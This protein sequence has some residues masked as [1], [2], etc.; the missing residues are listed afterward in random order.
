MRQMHEIIGASLAAVTAVTVLGGCAVHKEYDVRD[1]VDDPNVVLIMRSGTL[2]TRLAC[3]PDNSG[4][5]RALM[6]D[7]VD[8]RSAEQIAATGLANPCKDG[9]IEPAE[10]DNLPKLAAKLGWIK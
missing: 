9:I 5:L 2:L 7:N 10:H 8:V 4:S 3:S 6:G 1:Q